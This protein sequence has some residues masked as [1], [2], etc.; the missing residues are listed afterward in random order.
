MRKALRGFALALALV[1]MASGGWVIFDALTS[2]LSH[3]PVLERDWTA[4]PDQGTTGPLSGGVVLPGL[5][6]GKNGDREGHMSPDVMENNTLYI[7]ALGA[8]GP[9]DTSGDNGKVVDG[10]LGL[11]GPEK[12]TRWQKGSNVGKDSG[13]MLITGH[14]SYNGVR[15]VL[16]DLA[17]ATPGNIAYVKAN[18]GSVEAYQLTSMKNYDKQ[19]LPG[20]LWNPAGPKRLA[21]VTCGGELIRSGNSLHYE[22]NI[23]SYWTPIST[24]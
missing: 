10:V 15:G 5:E 11:P 23:V 2:N 13:T 1:L 21:V 19:S 16:H 12:V 3:P 18:N 9:I 8:Y 22:D 24:P 6:E 7:P 20:E 4:N 14:I 17:L